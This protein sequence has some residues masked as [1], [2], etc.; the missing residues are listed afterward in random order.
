MANIS[1]TTY[2]TNQPSL[3]EW[4]QEFKVGM[5]ATKKDDR[6]LDMMRSWEVSNG[7]L[8]FSYVANKLKVAH[9]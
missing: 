6:G 1:H 2:P 8:D 3:S 7:G 9:P 5:Q 4:L